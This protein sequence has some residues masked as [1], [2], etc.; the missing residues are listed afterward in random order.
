MALPA[1]IAL[2][3]VTFVKNRKTLNYVEWANNESMVYPVITVCNPLLFDR[4]RAQKS[5]YVF[6]RS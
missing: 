3:A 1:F 2:E 6:N 4:E 5:E